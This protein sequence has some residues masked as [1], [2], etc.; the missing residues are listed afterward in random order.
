MALKSQPTPVDT[1]LVEAKE[2]RSLVGALQY[3]PYT[4]PDIVHAVNKVCQKLKDPTQGDMK[5]VKRILRYLK[6][7]LH[8]GIKFLAHSPLKLYGFC[9]TD[10]AG[11]SD[12]RRSTTGYCIYLGANCI[13]W[14][15]KKQPTVS[16]SSSEA[17]YR[18]MA[19]T[20]AELV[21]ITFLLRD[22]G[23]ELHEPP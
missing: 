20:M 3:L 18:S 9:D 1:K 16:I 10:W 12:T 21:W 17:K 15:S 2:Y 7:T 22:V 23:I 4:C 13:S 11:C 14:S 19:S 5:A 6:G 8:Y